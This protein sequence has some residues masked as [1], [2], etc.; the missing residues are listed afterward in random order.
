M[1]RGEG[2]LSLSYWKTDG[3]GDRLFVLIMYFLYPGHNS[4]V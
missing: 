1:H 2:E 3:T 4:D